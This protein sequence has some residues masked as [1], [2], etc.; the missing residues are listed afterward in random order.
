MSGNIMP[1]NNP[2]DPDLDVTHRR[3]TLPCHIGREK[4][5]KPFSIGY[6]TMVSCV[7]PGFLSL[8]SKG[9]F[10]SLLYRV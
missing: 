7:L 4:T 5:L 6:L 2:C 9:S 1:A 10:F 3:F 8:G